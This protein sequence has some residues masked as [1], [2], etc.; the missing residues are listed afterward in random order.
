MQTGSFYI[1][2]YLLQL[3]G[4]L[5]A[6]LFMFSGE[7]AAHGKEKHNKAATKPLPQTTG[8]GLD[9]EPG[10]EPDTE[11]TTESVSTATDKESVPMLKKTNPAIHDA[12]ETI[13]YN[14]LVDV[15]SIFKQA[16]FDCHTSLTEYPWYYS[17]P[18]VKEMMEKDIEEA[19]E[20]LD[21]S[22]DYPFLSHGELT[23]DLKAIA[24]S[25]REKTMPPLPY[26]VMHWSTSLNNEQKSKVLQWVEHSLTL[27]NKAGYVA[28][29]D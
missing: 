28:S 22:N 10:T 13:A 2:R 21:F 17:L 29:A 19:R 24:K 23:S 25:I 15:K 5:V 12:I 18:L 26:T 4:W 9:T 20:H 14:Y 27:L 3:S 7:A 6:V 11:T 16:C 1:A 8:T